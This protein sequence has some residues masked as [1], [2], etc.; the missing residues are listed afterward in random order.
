MP[1]HIDETALGWMQETFDF[2]LEASRVAYR[3]GEPVG[4][5]AVQ[6][7]EAYR[8][9]DRSPLTKGRRDEAGAWSVTCF[10]V[11]PDHRQ[12]GLMT[13]LLKAAVAHARK[14]GAAAL[15]GYPYEPDKIDGASGYMGLRSVFETAGFR[16]V[17]RPAARRS[18]MRR[19]FRQASGRA[20]STP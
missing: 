3:D 7:R 15:E 20:G 6:P 17:A 18:I 1:F 19:A 13:T 5:I 4:W 14:H 12:T 11:H 16:E 2:D 9:L 8:A 10:F